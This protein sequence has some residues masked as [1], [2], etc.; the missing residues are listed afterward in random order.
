M[1]PNLETILSR[2][3]IRSYTGEGIAAS[4]VDD[5]L[6]AAMAA[7]SAG[8]QQPWHFVVIRERRILDAVP[9][10]HPYAAMVAEAPLAILACGDPRL[11]KYAGYWVQDLSAAV[12]NLLL[13]AHAK[14]LGAVWCGVY[15]TQERMAS[16]RSL[17]AVPEPVIPFALVAVGH[18][19]ESKPPAERYRSD[20]IHVDSWDG[21]KP[22]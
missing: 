16:F 6:R 21:Q 2:R 20:R 8:N 14:G 3:S 11:E 15:P 9:G 5:L 17:C 13:A 4:D 22:E 18:P 10:I 7:P 1:N 19:A 12:E